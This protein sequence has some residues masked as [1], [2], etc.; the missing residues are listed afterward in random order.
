MKLDFRQRLLTTTLLVGA[1]MAASPAF[2]QTTPPDTTAGTQPDATTAAQAPATAAPAPSGQDIVIT[3]TRIPQPNLTSAS[4]VTVLNSQDIKLQGTTRT[5]DLINSLPQSFAAQGSNISN[6]SS[7]TASV[8]LRGLGSQR[9]LVLINGRPLSTRWTAANV[10]GIVEAW[11]PGERG[12]EAVA[13]VLFGE[14][15]PSGRLSLTI[16]RHVGQFPFYYNFKPTRG[17]WNNGQLKMRDY[18]DMG[19]TPL[20]PFGHGLSYTKFEYGNLAVTPREAG[21]AG[22]ITVTAD[23]TNAG[24]RAGQETVQLYVR[25]VVS[26]VTRP[27]QELKGFEKVSL[28]PGEKKTVRFRLASGELSFLDREMKRIVEPGEYEA[29]VGASSQDIRLRGRFDIK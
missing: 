26:S 4:P 17:S 28:R 13:E 15:N 21:A 23:V 12:G 3:G 2:A 24:G 19:G 7:G 16:P 8:N 29:M 1:S 25:D 20:Y 6:G 14:Y 11:L 18:V 27:V 5:E 9:T 22:E 10:P